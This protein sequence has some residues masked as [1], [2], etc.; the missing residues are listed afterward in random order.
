MLLKIIATL[1]HRTKSTKLWF[2]TSLR[3][4]FWGFSG[5]LNYFF[6]MF[7]V[8]STVIGFC[9]CLIYRCCYILTRQSLEQWF[10]PN[11]FHW[12]SWLLFLMDLISFEVL[13]CFGKS[14]CDSRKY[15]LFS[16]FKESRLNQVWYCLILT[17]THVLH[18]SASWI[19]KCFPNNLL[20]LQ[21][22]LMVPHLD[23]R[24]EFIQKEVAMTPSVSLTTL[25]FNVCAVA[26]VMS[27]G[28]CFGV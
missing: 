13:V 24:M 27:F 19:S 25:I 20:C 28:N 12:Y 11:T 2:S 23:F 6:L 16:I 15:L 14:A 7:G 26:A 21:I 1:I 9:S 8:S 4:G 22:L 18:V 17:H 5:F 3:V 10:S